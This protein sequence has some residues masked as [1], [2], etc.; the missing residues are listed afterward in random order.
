VWGIGEEQTSPVES[1]RCQEWEVQ[2][3]PTCRIFGK[4]GQCKD[5]PWCPEVEALL[6]RAV[7][8]AD[9]SGR[10]GLCPWTG[11]RVPKWNSCPWEHIFSW[12]DRHMKE[13]STFQ[14]GRWHGSLEASFSSAVI[15]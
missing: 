4:I 9:E 7:S 5:K 11:P 8:G 2:T 15:Q 6:G 1:D 12:G 13:V 10:R 14:A 3:I